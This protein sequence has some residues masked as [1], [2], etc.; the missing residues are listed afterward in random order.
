MISGSPKSR[1]LK[2]LYRMMASMVER[3]DPTCVDALVRF[4][5]E[6]GLDTSGIQDLLKQNTSKG[7]RPGQQHDQHNVSDVSQA[8]S[9]SKTTQNLSK[10]KKVCIGILK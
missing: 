4:S 1:V 6:F 8:T 9:T 2:E 10:K 3:G 5:A 7:G